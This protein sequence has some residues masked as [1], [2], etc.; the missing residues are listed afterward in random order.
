VTCTRPKAVVCGFADT[1][2][3]D[4]KEGYAPS[5]APSAFKRHAGLKILLDYNQLVATNKV[6]RVE[7]IMQRRITIDGKIIILTIGKVFSNPPLKISLSVR[8]RTNIGI[9]NK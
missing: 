4:A 3:L 9:S 7:H 2:V 1:M 8:T 5:I 6:F